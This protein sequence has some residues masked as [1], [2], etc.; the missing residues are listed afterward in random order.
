MNI[1]RWY[2]DDVERIWA[3]AGNLPW[4][5]GF[6]GPEMGHKLSKLKHKELIVVV[7]SHPKIDY[8]KKWKLNP[9]ICDQFSGEPE[10]G[11]A[12]NLETYEQNLIAAR[13]KA[14]KYYNRNNPK[15]VADKIRRAPD[16]FS[17]PTIETLIHLYQVYQ[18]SAFSVP[19][20]PVPRHLPTLSRAGMVKRGDDK[21]YT[22]TEE[23]KSY[24]SEV[25]GL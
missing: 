21:M 16:R 8:L 5:S 17:P 22:L 19:E 1:P 11:H 14:E 20:T 2:R 13:K 10:P 4:Y 6:F 24:V 25:F 7:E 15:R 12:E 23:G 3:K 18:D 9:L